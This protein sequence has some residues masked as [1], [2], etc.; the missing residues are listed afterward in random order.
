MKKD[1]Q[2][3]VAASDTNTKHYL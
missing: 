3:F 1:M 2:Q